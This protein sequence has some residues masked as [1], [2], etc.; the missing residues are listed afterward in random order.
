LQKGIQTPNLKKIDLKIDIDDFLHIHKKA[1]PRVNREVDDSVCFEF[2]VEDVGLVLHGRKEARLV[3]KDR[4]TKN[5]NLVFIK[6]FK[7][8]A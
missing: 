6:V 1:L 4:R 8:I 7:K 3:L 5:H 2:E